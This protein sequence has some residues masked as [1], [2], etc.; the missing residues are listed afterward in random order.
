MRTGRGPL[1]SPAL[2]CSHETDPGLRGSAGGEAF[3]GSKEDPLDTQANRSGR[4]RRHQRSGRRQA[5]L[6]VW[7]FNHYANTPDRPAGVRHYALGKELVERGI[8]V[9]IFAA[10]YSHA[11]AEGSMAGDHRLMARETIDGIH[12]VWLRTFPYQ[13]ND[14]RRKL[15]MLSY[16]ALVIPASLT[17]PRPD[18]VI[19]STVHPF[20]ALAGWVAAKVRG[21]RYM[22]EVRDL[23]PQTLVDLGA[24]SPTGIGARGM[25]AIESFLV[26]RAE[27]VISL[28]PLISLYLE[29]RGLP[30]DHVRYLPNGAKLSEF[31]ATRDRLLQRPSRTLAG[32]LE[33]VARR[34]AAGEVVFTYTG[35]HGHVNRLDVVLDALDLVNRQTSHRLSVHFVGDGPEKE[36]LVARAQQMGL[37]NAIF[38]DP[39]P[40]SDLPAFLASVDVGLVHTTA[41]PVYRYGISFNKLFDYM[42]AS[43]PV[44]FATTTAADPVRASGAGLTVAPDDPQAL[45]DGM[46]ALIEAGPDGRRQM[47]ERG[48]DFAELEHD[49]DV[50]GARLAAILGAPDQVLGPT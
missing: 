6:S 27:A 46:I 16:S 20:A 30:S 14:W 39:V 17:R 36:R 12:F 44:A 35:Q 50:L 1:Y 28:L 43:L 29:S 15:N 26:R 9:T 11:T 8:E 5:P 4:H 2:S 21:A 40:K 23:W 47:G 42:A 24:L 19:G 34:R 49:M 33:E 38:H 22:Y 37:H 10:G 31:D 32:L 13:V 41:T 48:R 45:A 18:I 3:V 25:W 7:I